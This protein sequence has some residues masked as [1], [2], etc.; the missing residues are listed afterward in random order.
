VKQAFFERTL[1]LMETALNQELI[2]LVGG[3]AVAQANLLNEEL[4]RRTGKKTDD[5]SGT[6]I[7]SLNYLTCWAETPRFI[8]LLGTLNSEKEFS[9]MPVVVAF[10]EFSTT[11][12]WAAAVSFL[13][14]GFAVQLGTQL[15]FWGSPS[16]AEVILKDWPAVSGG[17]LLTSP[18]PPDGHAQAQEM[19][20]HIQSRSF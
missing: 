17:I 4:A 9:Q 13:S 8:K 15:P 2:V 1:T 19:I 16:L 14:L 12:T 10:P 18:S 11:S 3:G 20:L 5:I 6:G 7:R